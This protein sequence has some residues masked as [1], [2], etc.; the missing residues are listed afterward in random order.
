[1]KTIRHAIHPSELL[2]HWQGHR[3]LTKRVIEAFSEEALFNYS[4]GCMRPFSEIALEIITIS[5]LS[6]RHIIQEIPLQETKKVRSCD[7]K[8]SL[9]ALWDETTLLIDS[10]WN[11]L[12]L[13]R[14][15][16]TI[17]FFGIDERK[18]YEAIFY[19]IDNEIHHR[20]QAYVYLRGLGVTPP[21]FHER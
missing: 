17:D 16:K 2:A 18:I 10:N 7:T 13:E 6:V 9:L 3:A 5:T 19:L 21:I 4:I 14:F 1:M 15:H 11:T 8:T 20:G 12:R